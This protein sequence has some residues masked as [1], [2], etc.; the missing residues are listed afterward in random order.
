MWPLKR[1]DEAQVGRLAAGLGLPGPMARVMWL[2]G[3]RGVED[4]RRWLAVSVEQLHAPSLLPDFEPAL[5]RVKEAADRQE[6]VLVW[7]HDDL[8]GIT[9]SAVLRR[10][11]EELGVRTFHHIPVKGRD[12]YGLNPEVC[13]Q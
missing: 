11:L 7:G 5:S 3:V 9:A 8:D 1:V 12:K 10:V 2:R 13:Q 6:S 4:A